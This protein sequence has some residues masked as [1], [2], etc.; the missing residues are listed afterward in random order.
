MLLIKSTSNITISVKVSR[1]LLSKDGTRK[2]LFEL[3]DGKNRN[4]LYS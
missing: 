4:S 2:W 3:E 1:S